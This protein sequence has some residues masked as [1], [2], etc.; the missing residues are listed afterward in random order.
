V[1]HV[2]VHVLP[3]KAGDFEPN[4]RVYDELEG[5]EKAM[6]GDFAAAAA[7]AAG[8][9]AGA[10]AGGNTL[11]LDVERQPRTRQE[12]AAEAAELRALFP[13]DAGAL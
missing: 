7:A 1:P 6:A 11:N 2:H 8:T 10:G 9:A 12:M 3:R 13:V 4:D 5:G